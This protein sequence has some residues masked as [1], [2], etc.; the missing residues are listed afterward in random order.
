MSLDLSKKKVLDLSKK[1]ETVIQKL[2][3]SKFRARVIFVAD[4]SG[5]MKSLYTRGVMQNVYERI[6]ALAL[7]FDDNGSLE[8]MVFDHGVLDLPEATLDDIGLYVERNIIKNPTIK[9]G[10]TNYAPPL[11]KIRD[12]VA[13]RPK[14]F[15][16]MFSKPRPASKDPVYVVFLTD[17]ENYD[18]PE[19]R[20]ALIELS[21]F[22]VFVKFL[23]IGSSRFP[24]LEK[25][26]TM[27]GRVVDNANFQAITDI[28][29]ISD[30]EL[31]HRLL[32]EVSD[33]EQA[34]KAAQVL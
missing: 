10:M 3:L 19:T 30:E 22:P 7:K 13:V 2:N 32:V 4:V 21:A 14:G 15:F 23:G 6:M 27:D 28:A 24:M 34:A 18:E 5:S 33:W 11:R 16:A 31:Y 8:N 26:D 1:A 9:W 17:G 12:M 29:R 20:Q 25:L